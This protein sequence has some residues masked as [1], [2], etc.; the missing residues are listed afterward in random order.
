MP[1]KA[2]KVGRSCCCSCI[3][4]QVRHLYTLFLRY[5]YCG[6]S[7]GACQLEA[8]PTLL[9]AARDVQGYSRLLIDDSRT[10]PFLF[11]DVVL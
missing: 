10:L 4:W 3:R 11:L 1:S 8:S 5:M 9:L 6:S 7:D 2:R